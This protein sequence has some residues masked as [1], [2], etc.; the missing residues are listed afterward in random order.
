MTGLRS[1][2]TVPATLLALTG[3]GGEAGGDAELAVDSLLVEALVDL[4]LA[5]ARAALDSLGPGAADSLRHA[6]LAAHALDSAALSHRLGALAEAPD[7]ARATYDAVDDRLA[8]ER[9]GA[10]PD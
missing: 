5:D 1:A 8:E 6:A 10:L 9:R 3:C 7:V 4:H 2:L